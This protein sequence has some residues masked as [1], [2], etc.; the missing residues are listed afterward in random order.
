MTTTP[1]RKRGQV[2]DGRM[3]GRVPGTTVAARVRS[4]STGSCAS[5]LMESAE[6]DRSLTNDGSTRWPT[7]CETQ[8]DH[9]APRRPRTTTTPRNVEGR[10][11]EGNRPSSRGAEGTRT[12]DPLHAME[13][14]YQLR[15]SPS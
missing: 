1:N 10:L 2:A 14:R 9:H 3:S 15:H 11:P 8:T 7:Q 5:T 13:V 6:R 4:G 12:P